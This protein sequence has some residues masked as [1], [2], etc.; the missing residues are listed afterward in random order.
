MLLKINFSSLKNLKPSEVQ[1]DHTKVKYKG[2]EFC[3]WMR[4]EMWAVEVWLKTPSKH[5][6]LSMHKTNNSVY[7]W[8]HL[9]IMEIWPFLG[10]LSLFS[11]YIKSLLLVHVERKRSLNLNVIWKKTRFRNIF[12]SKITLRSLYVSKITV[13]T[14]WNKY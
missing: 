9:A 11:C 8:L 3:I 13:S 5:G 10:K 7:N 1:T 12:L 6:M 14:L 2:V 4:S